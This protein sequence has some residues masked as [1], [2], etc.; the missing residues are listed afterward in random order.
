MSEQTSPTGP[1][2]MEILNGG[3]LVEIIKSNGS[4]EQVKVR[5]LPIGDMPEY[6]GLQ[7][8]ER[9]LIELLCGKQNRALSIRLRNAHLTEERLQGLLA[10]ATLENTIAIEK[11][12]K[13]VAE[14]I[15]KMQAEA[16][17]FADS[18]TEE[19]FVKILE[20]GE[21]LN[22]P[23]FGRWAERRKTSTG[24]FMKATTGQSD[25]PNSTS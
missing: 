14:E 15:A 8:N 2:E 5:Q 12:M 16:T 9:A 24:R 22:L 1:T 7:G 20:E 3:V 21:R 13:R 6:G 18:L 11:E 23:R 25:G 10:T 19:S 4:V 17:D